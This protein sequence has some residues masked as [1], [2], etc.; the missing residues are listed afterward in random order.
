MRAVGLTPA[1]IPVEVTSGPFVLALVVGLVVTL[2]WSPHGRP[3]TD[4]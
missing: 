3:G 1:G 4:R 2:L